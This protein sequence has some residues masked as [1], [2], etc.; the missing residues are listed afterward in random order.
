MRAITRG[1]RCDQLSK[2]KIIV[3]QITHAH[4][5]T[6]THTHTHTQIFQQDAGH[7]TPGLFFKSAISRSLGRYGS[8]DLWISTH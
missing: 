7:I 1:I 3:I 5:H 8:Q 2:N 6:R 4:A